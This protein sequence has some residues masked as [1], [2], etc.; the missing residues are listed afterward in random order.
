MHLLPRETV[1]SLDVGPLGLTELAH[2]ADK[3]VTRDRVVGGSLRVLGALSNRHA[4]VP[5]LPLVIPGRGLGRRAESDVLIQP[6]F[7]RHTG[8]VRQ[9]FLLSRIIPAPVAV[10]RKAVAVNDGLQV[11]CTTRIRVCVP[12][13]YYEI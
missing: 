7:L 4:S 1:Q 11:H 3:K 6:I 2:R 13:Q 12:I 8:Q 5:L 10:G 9:D